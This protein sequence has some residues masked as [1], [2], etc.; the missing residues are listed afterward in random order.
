MHISPKLRN[1]KSRNVRHAPRYETQSYP[2]SPSIQA[3][4]VQSIFSFSLTTSLCTTNVP[5]LVETNDLLDG[6]NTLHD[7][8]Y[9]H[10]YR[11]NTQV[12]QML[13]PSHV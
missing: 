2:K 5:K 13:V 11:V 7:L 3:F 1:A 12:T 8:S 10:E 6:F 4:V 9:Y